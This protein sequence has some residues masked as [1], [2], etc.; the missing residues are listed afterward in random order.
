VSLTA[1]RD[2]QGELIG[3]AKAAR[4]L[5]ARREQEAMLK[6]TI[7]EAE[8]A[9]IRAEEANRSKGQFLAT[10]SHEIRTPINAVVGYAD[11]LD[12]EIA[13]PLNADQQGY[14]ARVRA[15]S[16]HLL[17]I[18]DE[19]LDFSRLEANRASLDIREGRL[20]GPLRDALQM[21]QIQARG[22]GVDISDGTAGTMLDAS[23]RGDEDR[24]RQILIVL[25]SNAVKFTPAG[26][27][28][29]VA[30]GTADELPSDVKLSGEGPWVYVRI[31]DTG[32]GIPPAR[33]EAIFDLFE[34]ADMSLTREHGGTG[35]GLTIAR[36]L[37]LLMAGDLSV[38]STPGVGSSFFVWLP[39]AAEDEVREVKSSEPP[40]ASQERP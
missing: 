23:Y 15:C 31:E 24:V 5:T 13:G 32:P 36:R 18:I 39:A 30:A 25:L 6:S 21:V 38:R 37:A 12:A 27:R 2:T 20:S 4:D 14:L 7:E 28:V 10:M 17:G 19:V 26:G 1:L 11:L 8:Q 40:L 33:M 16:L 29:T 3:F 22:K 9:R 34:Q 35:L